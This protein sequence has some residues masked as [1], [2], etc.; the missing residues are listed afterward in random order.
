MRLAKI[1]G[2]SGKSKVERRKFLTVENRP[3]LS[4]LYFGFDFR[5]NLTETTEIIE[6][7][8]ICQKFRYIFDIFDIRY[9]GSENYGTNS[10]IL[11][12]T[13]HLR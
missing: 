3:K 6:N 10:L 5:E 2:I 9:Q 7:F 13:S 8:N 4:R 11:L 12:F 1:F